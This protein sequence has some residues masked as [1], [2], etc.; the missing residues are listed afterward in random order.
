[1]QYIH[2][3]IYMYIHTTQI[4]YI[5]NTCIRYTIYIRSLEKN[6]FTRFLEP[7]RPSLG[8]DDLQGLWRSFDKDAVFCEM[9]GD[10]TTIE[11][12]SSW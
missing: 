1:M 9:C 10:Q 3:Y 11:A 6:W 8:E 12:K 5:Y 7:H 4:I 2:I